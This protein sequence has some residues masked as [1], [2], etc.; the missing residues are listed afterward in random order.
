MRSVSSQLKC[1][2]LVVCLFI[3]AQL[4]AKGFPTFPS[5]RLPFPAVAGDF[6][7]DGKVD[8]LSFSPCDADSCSITVALGNG[9]NGFGPP[10]SSSITHLVQGFT[11]VGDFNG[12]HKLDV[13]FLSY[14]PPTA[15]VS[16]AM[17]N[18]DGTFGPVS[19]IPVA[20]PPQSLM[21][22]DVNGDGKLDLV[23]VLD[24]PPETIQVYLGKGNG[25]FQALQSSL[26]GLPCQLADINGDG[27]LDLVGNGIYLGNGNGTFQSQMPMPG[28]GGCPAIAD[29]NGD[30]K[31]DFAVLAGNGVTVFFGNGDATFQSGVTYKGGENASALL[32]ADF[33][34]DG[35]PDLFLS[36]GTIFLNTGKGTFRPPVR[37]G[38]GQVPLLADVNRDGRS[39]VIFGVV[40]SPGISIAFARPDGTFAASHVYSALYLDHDFPA[41]ITAG[42]FTG[43]G[44][45]DLAVTATFTNGVAGE[46]GRLIGKGDGT[47]GSEIGG[48]TGGRQSRFVAS[49]DLNHDGHLDLATASED[50]INIRLG[51]EGTKLQPPVSYSAASPT[52][53]AIADFNRDGIPDIA[54]NGSSG[55]VLLGNGDGTFRSGLSLPAGIQMLL[56]G[57][58]N[59]DGTPDLAILATS[60]IGIMLGNGDGTFKPAL[61]YRAR[62]GAKLATADF[63]NDGRLDLAEVSPAPTGMLARIFLGNGDGTLATP[64][65][66]A[67]NLGKAD[68]PD[69]VVAVD[70]NA[71]GNVDLAMTIPTGGITILSGK[72]SGKF[73]APSFYFTPGS[74]G[75]HTLLAADLD[76]N[77][78][79]DLAVLDPLVGTITVLLN[80]P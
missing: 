72:G 37:Y 60:G 1:G 27:K 70:F 32:V 16:V 78:T 53:L 68:G 49:A 40:R 12:D 38:F 36:D 56:A 64:L 28:P 45:T 33:N 7:G 11:V 31:L 57:D 14:G 2:A 8:L 35:K 51:L 9:T 21:V 43:D 80:T 63:N 66:T 5:Y 23:V 67:I 54:A 71:D 26:P 62:P 42:D 3:S 48:L 39:D 46:L 75:L 20:A 41:S 29:F 52:M 17:G 59:N 10:V 50:S 30:G 77:G 76:G 4:L 6:N 13:A 34:G 22:G 61:F 15:F 25:T 74:F 65:D 73:G 18:G 69:G 24:F 55:Q 47:F 19:N 79:P 58:F 44:K